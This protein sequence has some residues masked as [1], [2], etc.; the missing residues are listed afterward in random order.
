MNL[1]NKIKLELLEQIEINI[2]NIYS[3]NK[4]PKLLIKVNE[5][6]QFGDFTTMAALQ[7]KSTVNESSIKIAKEITENINIL[8]AE[9]IK[10]E[11]VNPG[12]INFYLDPS[13][14]IENLEDLIKSE[15][16]LPNL[17]LSSSIR[18]DINYIIKR[19]ENLL[20]A[21]ENDG[22]VPDYTKIS[23]EDLQLEEEREFFNLYTRICQNSLTFSEKELNI[24][25]EETINKFYL[26]H[27]KLQFRKL[28]QS[29]LNIALSIFIGLKRFLHSL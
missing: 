2:R 24:L 4:F 23:W 22:L 28:E 25:I 19:I 27:D 8:S 10:V 6:E 3:I 29:R 21:F 20:M 16:K 12:Y 15:F 14:K 1:V 17:V 5:N 7:L 11:V 9:V 26:Y 18:E 13:W